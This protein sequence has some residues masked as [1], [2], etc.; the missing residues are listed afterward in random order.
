MQLVERWER[1]PART[2]VARAGA[3]LIA[4]LALLLLASGP[5][6]AVLDE[7][8]DASWRLELLPVE[9]SP[10]DGTASEPR[11]LEPGSDDALPA[12]PAWAVDQLVRRSE[13]VAPPGS[14]SAAGDAAAARGPP[15][16]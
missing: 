9:P 15:L 12:E 1:A 5:V 16:R 11:V 4:T 13:L 2:A 3:I 8:A 10:S 14:T 6:V 7:L